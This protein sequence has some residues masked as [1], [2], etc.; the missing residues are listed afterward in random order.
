MTL[1]QAPPSAKEIYGGFWI[2]LGSLFLD[3]LIVLPIG[4]FFHFAGGF[5]RVVHLYTIAPHFMVLIFFHVYC[6]KRWGGTPGKLIVGLKIVK[7]NGE[8]VGWREAFVRHS[9]MLALSL[10][11][12]CGTTAAALQLPEDTYGMATFMERSLLLAGV[13]PVF[14]QVVSWLSNI[15]VYGEF[16]VLLTNEKRKAI[17]D[18]MAGTVVINEKYQAFVRQEASAL[19]TVV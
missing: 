5:G 10:L 13:F 1:N 15:W 6:V 11:T 4:L 7:E 3:F 8:D 14:T 2:R 12:M 18:Y 9:V 19:S 16:M 17:H